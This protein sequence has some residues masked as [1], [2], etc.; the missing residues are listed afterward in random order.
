MP[1][2]TETTDEKA[3]SA[4]KS[5]DE[6]A[7]E[8]SVLEKEVD[9]SGLLQN[10]LRVAAPCLGNNPRRLKHYQNLLRLQLH[11][12]HQLGLKSD[13]PVTPTQLAKLVMIE[14][15]RPTLYRALFEDAD[16]RRRFMNWVA[17]GLIMDGAG[18]HRRWALPRMMMLGFGSTGQPSTAQNSLQTR[19][20][21]RS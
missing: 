21:L 5:A 7:E 11:I 4:Q 13:G 16:K 14:I 9:G 3:K 1:K 8:A 15:A 17:V 12:G 19:T 20:R 18:R 6:V 10:A 2:P